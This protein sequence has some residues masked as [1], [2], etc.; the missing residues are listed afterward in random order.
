MACQKRV[1]QILGY[2]LKQFGC[3]AAVVMP[4]CRKLRTDLGLELGE[5]D[6]DF[7]SVRFRHTGNISREFRQT[8][9]AFSSC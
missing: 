7:G 1:C 2:R 6:I 3:L 8:G 4:L 9:R 5:L